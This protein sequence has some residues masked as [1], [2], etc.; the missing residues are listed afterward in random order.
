MKKKTILALAAV[1][2]VLVGLTGFFQFPAVF[3][4]E[5]TTTDYVDG[6]SDVAVS[7]TRCRGI[8]FVYRSCETQVQAPSETRPST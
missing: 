2:Y 5:R 8:P 7:V 6:D 1:A 3:R 4:V